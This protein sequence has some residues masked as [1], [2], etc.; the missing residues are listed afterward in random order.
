MAGHLKMNLT[1]ARNVTPRE[2]SN[3]E[4]NLVG[5]LVFGGNFHLKQPSKKAIK[6]WKLT[7]CIN[8]FDTKNLPGK[9][10]KIKSIFFKGILY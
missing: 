3:V 6:K 2:G 10:E 1:R 8:V 5:Q 4:I 9:K 7:Y